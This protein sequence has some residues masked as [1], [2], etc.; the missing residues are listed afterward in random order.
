MHA[1]AT[2]LVILAPMPGLSG[3]SIRTLEMFTGFSN[4]ASQAALVTL[5][6]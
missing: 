6:L 4:P 2:A 1:S 5:A 3:P